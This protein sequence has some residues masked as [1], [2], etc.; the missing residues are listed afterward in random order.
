MALPERTAEAAHDPHPFPKAP[1]VQGSLLAAGL[2]HSWREHWQLLLNSW[3]AT[4]LLCA[5]A[6][7][8][9]RGIYYFLDF[10][11]GSGRWSGLFSVL[12]AGCL[13]MGGFGLLLVGRLSR[14]DAARRAEATAWIFGGLGGMFLALDELTQ[15]H[16][17]LARWLGR[18]GVPPPFGLGDQDG[19]VFAAYAACACYAGLTVRATL[20]NWPRTWL[21]GLVAVACFAASTAV[22]FVPWNAL[23]R[24]QQEFWGS[25]EE[26][27]KTLG[28]VNFAVFAALL[29]DCAAKDRDFAN[30][31]RLVRS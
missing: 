3:L 24:P 11:D 15:L 8:W 20:A 16:E 28:C 7:W 13:A 14:T 26:I 22:D 23:T 21:P 25:I 27:F 18:H 19:Y 29:V 2:A 6:A 10:R 5:A 12:T 31:R 30:A 1:L 9:G 4:I 17:S